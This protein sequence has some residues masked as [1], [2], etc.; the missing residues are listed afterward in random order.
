M[1]WNLSKGTSHV[2]IPRPAS[3]WRRVTVGP[4]A[5]EPRTVEAH[6]DSAP[7]VASVDRPRAPLT[8]ASL[9]PVAI[10]GPARK[11]PNDS[12]LVVAK[13]GDSAARRSGECHRA[14][15]SVA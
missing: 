11:V 2:A 8:R 1:V 14:G 6:Y 12:S 15:G 3:S 7:M 10:N 4:F 9:D 5:V 13:V